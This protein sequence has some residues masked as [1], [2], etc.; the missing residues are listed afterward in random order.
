MSN[1]VASQ[2]DQG[3]V[4]KQRIREALLHEVKRMLRDDGLWDTAW[5]DKAGGYMDMDDK[6]QGGWILIATDVPGLGNINVHLNFDASE[7]HQYIHKLVVQ[8]ILYAY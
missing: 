8:C 4:Y 6:W 1:E 7:G 2:G 5:K 3:E